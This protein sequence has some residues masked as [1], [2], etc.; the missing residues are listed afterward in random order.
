VQSVG[1][2]VHTGTGTVGHVTQAA[3][4]VVDAS[5]ATVG[6]AGT[7]ATNGGG[8]LLGAGDVVHGT[9]DQIVGGTPISEK[10]TTLLSGTGAPSPTDVAPIPIQLPEH[11]TSGLA[12]GL[13]DASQPVPNGDG[14]LLSGL[15]FHAPGAIPAG[16]E[17]L[18]MTAAAFTLA[19]VA[20][21]VR[22][23][24][25]ATA[26]FFLANVRQVPAMCGGVTQ[27]VNRPIAL[28]AASSSQLF[29]LATGAPERAGAALDDMAKTIG[30]GFRRGRE[31]GLPGAENRATD[32]GE[33]DTRLLMQIGM[34]LGAVYVAFLTVWFWATRLRWNPRI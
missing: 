27:V 19:T 7:A 6:A 18:A 21:A 22:P 11:V 10:V 16:D 31:G 8:S 14:G 34:L 13:T 29:E 33:R 4:S 32:D 25:V 12:P 2:V 15:P 1:D 20:I 30:D 9:T 28:A 26:Q 24:T 17:V 5:T 3:T 23:S